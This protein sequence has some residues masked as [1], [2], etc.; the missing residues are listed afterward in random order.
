MVR[1]WN[2]NQVK[3]RHRDLIQGFVLLSSPKSLSV[4]PSAYAVTEWSMY[5]PDTI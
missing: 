2:L 3:K 1:A 4:F 5:R